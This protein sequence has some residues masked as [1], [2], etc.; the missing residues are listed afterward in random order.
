MTAP[1]EEPTVVGLCNC[2]DEPVLAGD[3]RHV[4]VHRATGAA[5]DLLLHR[6]S[7]RPAETRRWIGR[8][9]RC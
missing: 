5:P 4:E 6:Q 3:E 9:Y 2:C 8:S 7:C 1:P